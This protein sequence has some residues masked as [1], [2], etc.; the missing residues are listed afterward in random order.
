MGYT[1]GKSPWEKFGSGE[2]KKPG[3]E[4]RSGGETTNVR[5]C[6]LF[7]DGASFY[8]LGMDIIEVESLELFFGFF[9]GLCL[10]VEFHSV[11]EAESLFIG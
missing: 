8:I 11:G 2:R 9:L 5:N 1:V 10:D 7:F 6:L 3:L 4:T